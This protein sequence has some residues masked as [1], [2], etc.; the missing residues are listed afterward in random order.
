MC[1]KLN[2]SID[3]VMWGT[4]RDQ[5]ILYHGRYD[6]DELLDDCHLST[7][8]E[9]TRLGVAYLVVDTYLRIMQPSSPSIS[10]AVPA[11]QFIRDSNN[12]LLDGQQ[13]SSTLL[14]AQYSGM[15]RFADRKLL[16]NFAAKYSFLDI[17][18]STLVA[19]S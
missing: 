6:L 16:P 2:A 4:L 18:S 9:D 10:T 3:F 13:A 14:K 17:A 1:R 12:C 15:N 5:L 11:T 7:V 8:I 19:G